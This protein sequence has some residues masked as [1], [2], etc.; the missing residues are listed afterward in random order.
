ML[1]RCRDIAET[2]IPKSNHQIREIGQAFLKGDRHFSVGELPSLV[3]PALLK[4][5]AHYVVAV[6]RVLQLPVWSKG[7]AT[8]PILL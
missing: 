2:P 5:L 8:P 4:V 6:W 3:V 7:A 1:W